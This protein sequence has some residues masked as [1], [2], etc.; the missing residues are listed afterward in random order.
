MV[1]TYWRLV[2]DALQL[3]ASIVFAIFIGAGLGYWLDGKFG[4]FP[5]LSIIFFF[6][7]VAAAARNVWV[8][9]RKQL[10]SEKDKDRL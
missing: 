4:T 2:G 8:E 5:Y 9:V 7:G 10:R 3:G 6:L 1:S